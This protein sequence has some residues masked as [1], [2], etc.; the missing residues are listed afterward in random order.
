MLRASALG[1]WQCEMAVSSFCFSCLH[2]CC[3]AILTWLYRPAT[4]VLFVVAAFDRDL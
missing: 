4:S 2:H 3:A 1:Q